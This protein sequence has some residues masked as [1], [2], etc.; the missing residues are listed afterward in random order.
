[1]IH[2]PR[3]PYT[4]GS[5][6]Q[7][8]GN[9]LQSASFEGGSFAGWAALPSSG[10]GTA[11]YKSASSHDGSYFAEMNTGTAGAGASLYQDVAIDTTP[12]QSFS[13]SVWMRS[14]TATHEGVCV[15]LWGLGG[16]Q[17]AGQTCV[18][19]TSRAW[20]LITAP[21]DTHASAHTKL[22]AQIYMETT[23][24]N[25]D[26]DGTELVNTGLQSASFEGGS[27]AG[28]AA[29]PSSGVG[30]AVYKSA[31]SHDGSYFAEM[32]TGTAG[33]G[34]SL[35]QD[36]AI[37]TT[38]GQSF[39]FSVWMRSPGS[40]HEGVCVVLWGLGGT[41]EA[42]QTCVT[43]TSSAW[44]L[45]TAPLDTHASADTK[46]RAQIYMETTNTNY[47]LDGTELVNTG[48]QSASFEGGSFAGWA[49]LPSSGVGTAVYKNASSH[50]GSYFAEMNTGTAGAGAL[51]YQDVAIDT[52]PGQSFSFSVWMRSPGSTHE[53]VCVVLW[54][55][56][57]TQEAGQ[58]CVTLTSSAWRLITAPLDTHASAHTKLRAQIYMETT[59]TNYDLDGTG[60]STGAGR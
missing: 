48:L 42:G 43:L 52:T 12:G 44:R 16:T 32:N 47:D 26:L 23:N 11:V 38:P 28:W 1:M 46:L 41:Q 9:L 57:G 50:D 13:F 55:L 27:F 60:I 18:T 17:E 31:S 49:A 22:R 21:L 35:Y 20:R 29:L 14:P 2:S 53:G 36:V 58:T 34:A 33:A 3:N 45:I 7:P 37:D 6:S 56:G 5:T 25:Y 24:T 4:N 30:T 8:A 40:T 54:G 39:S 15:V 59:N 10:V 51:L 19:L